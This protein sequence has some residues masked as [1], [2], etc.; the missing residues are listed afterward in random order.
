VRLCEAPVKG[1]SIF[2]F[3]DSAA[4]AKDYR[5]LAERVIDDGIRQ[6]KYP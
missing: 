2:E 5:K 4:G 1:Q 3:A 6:Q